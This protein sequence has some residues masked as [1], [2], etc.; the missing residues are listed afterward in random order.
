MH[1]RL[2]K[3]LARAGVAS[4]RAA[5]DLIRAGRVSVNGRIVT[6]LGSQA[7]SER[8]DVRLDGERIRAS[9]A[10]TLVLHKPMGV[11]TTLDDPEGRTTVRHLLPPKLGRVFPVGRLDFNS[12][13]LLILTNDGE[14]AARLM[15]PKHRIAR[16]Y[17]VKV[18]GRPGSAALGRLRKGIKLEEGVTGPAQVDVETELPTKTWLRITLR[19]G[20]RRE[21]RRMCEA[22]GHRVDRLVRVRFGP[23]EL[24]QLRPGEWRILDEEEI[25][26][27]RRAVGLGGSSRSRPPASRA[28][29][30]SNRR[31]R[32]ASH[33]SSP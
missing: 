30:P 21:I 18:S 2:Q 13:G 22:V 16:T 8:D 20:R 14:L 9:Q 28:E 5:E 24:G 10:L 4:R 3:L 7:D 23:L 33:R 6:E 26:A 15:H 25:D 11:V 32:S 29:K 12:A 27:V 17:R 1:E 19:E 31:A